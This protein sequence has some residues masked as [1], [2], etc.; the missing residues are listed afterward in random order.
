MASDGDGDGDGDIRD[1]IDRAFG[2]RHA[3]LS[4][5]ANEVRCIVSNPAAPYELAEWFVRKIPRLPHDDPAEGDSAPSKRHRRAGGANA[6]DM[7]MM[8]SDH[9]GNSDCGEIGVRTDLESLLEKEL[10][11]LKQHVRRPPS[12]QSPSAFNQHASKESAVDVLKQLYHAIPVLPS[13]TKPQPESVLF[14]KCAQSTMAHLSVLRGLMPFENSWFAVFEYEKYS[15]QDVLKYNRHVLCDD[16]DATEGAQLALSDMKKRFLIYQLMRVLQFFHERGLVMAGFC[17]SNILLTD[18]LWIRLGALPVMRLHHSDKTSLGEPGK[19]ELADTPHRNPPRRFVRMYRDV[20]DVSDRSITE[21]WC[22]GEV[23][24]FEYLML[25]NTASGR[26]MVDG[27]FHPVLPWVTDFSQRH[28]GWRDLTKSK[29]RINKGDSQLDRTYESSMIPHHITESVDSL[30]EITY[31]IYMARRT[32]MALLRQVVRS[33][34]QA[35]E[36]PS[37]M[38]RMY[39]WTPD[40][41]IPEFYMDASIFKSMHGDEMDDLAWPEWCESAE[42]FIHIHRAMLESDEVSQHLHH[43]IN[44]NFG[45]CLSGDEAVQAKNVPLRV[46]GG[47]RL[48]KSPGFAQLFTSAHPARRVQEIAASPPRRSIILDSQ[49]QADSNDY[50]QAQRLASYRPSDLKKKKAQMLSKALQIASEASESTPST[51]NET[52]VAAPKITMGTVAAT[53]H[54][55]AGPADPRALSVA[56]LRHRKKGNKARPRS[57]NSAEPNSPTGVI[58]P[59]GGHV[60]SPS[61]SRLATAIPKFFNSDSNGPHSTSS[62]QSVTSHFHAAPAGF[63]FSGDATAPNSSSMSAVS[64]DQ[65]RTQSMPASMS[66]VSTSSSGSLSTFHGHNNVNSSSSGIHIGSSFGGTTSTPSSGSSHIFKEIWQQISKPDEEESSLLSDSATMPEFDWSDTDYSCL[67]DVGIQLLN[68]GLPINL[69]TPNEFQSKHG[70]A[71]GV[72]ALEIERQ[73]RFCRMADSVISAAYSIPSDVLMEH[74]EID[75]LHMSA[76]DLD[77][78]ADLF[79]LGCVIAEIYTLTPLFSKNTVVEYVNAFAEVSQRRRQSLLELNW[80]PLAGIQPTSQPDVKLQVDYDADIQCQLR[81]VPL[82]IK[83]TITALIYPNPRRRL[84]LSGVLYGEEVS[85]LLHQFDRQRQVNAVV[86]GANTHSSNQLIVASQ[87]AAATGFSPAQ[88]SMFPPEFSK[89]YEFLAEFH[90]SNQWLERFDVVRKLLPQISTLPLPA[91]QTI[92]PV[93]THFFQA[94]SHTESIC[95]ERVVTAIVFLLPVLAQQL[96]RNGTA[97]ELL[98]DVLRVYENGQLSFLLKIC[99]AS[100]E[101]LKNLVRAFG[102]AIFIDQFLPVI[103]DWLATPPYAP[104]HNDCG[105]IPPDSRKAPLFATEASSIIAVAFGELVSVDILGPSLSVKYVLPMILPLLGKIKAKWNK[106]SQSS[107]IVQKNAA[108]STAMI[109]GADD[110]GSVTIQSAE[111]IHITYLCKEALYDTHFIADAVLLVCREMGEVPICATLLPYI[112]DVLPKLITLAERAGSARIEGVPAELGREIYVILCILR[113]QVRSMSETAVQRELLN[114]RPDSLIDLL[115]LISPP[116]LH[117]RTAAAVMAAASHSD[118]SDGFK[119]RKK[120][121]MQTLSYMRHENASE[122]RA[123]TAIGLARTIVAV[124]QKVG[125]EVAAAVTPLIQGINKFLTRCSVVYSELEVSNFQWHMA[126]E[127]VSEFC[128]PLK[129]L[130]GR[131]FFDKLFP[132]VHSS[133]VLQLLLLPIQSTATNVTK[134]LEGG[135]DSIIKTPLP[136]TTH[137]DDSVL[138][139]TREVTVERHDRARTLTDAQAQLSQVIAYPKPLLRFAYRTLRLNTVKS[140]GFLH[141]PMGL[142]SKDQQEINEETFA[143]Q[144]ERR[145]RKHQATSSSNAAAASPAKS[146]I[147]NASDQVWLRPLVTRPFM[148]RSAQEAA[149]AHTTTEAELMGHGS[150]AGDIGQSWMFL[151]EVRSTIKAHS[152]CV[153]SLS[154]DFDEEVALSGSKNGSCRAWRLANH[155]THVQAAVYTDSPITMVQHAMDGVNALA[156]EAGCVYIWDLSTSHARAKLPFHDDTVQGMAVLRTMPFGG[157]C[158]RAHDAASSG[159]G[160]ATRFCQ[161]GYADVVVATTRKVHTIDLRCGPRVVT[162]WRADARDAT[163][164]SA[165]AAVVSSSSGV[166]YQ[167]VGM[168]SGVVTLLCQ[169][170][171]TLVLQWQAL[172]SKVVKIVQYA[173]DLVLVVGAEKE[174]R[175]WALVPN[176]KPRLCMVLQ[177]LPEGLTAH[178]V[179]VQSYT[180]MALMYVVAG[181][182]VSTVRLVTEPTH[183]QSSGKSSGDI[184]ALRLEPWSITE[185]SVSS[186]LKLGKSK[187]AAQSIAVLPLRQVVVLGGDDGLI[188]LCV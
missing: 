50:R 14:A 124:C 58:G 166:V 142:D 53:S 168:S 33:N 187:V 119:T 116:F 100:P 121:V 175:V 120:R 82:N 170:M 154:V 164:M 24:N 34:F 96:G 71:S 174:A 90:M 63:T 181:S 26:R 165:V 1:E 102:N 186:S 112:F 36:Y 105:M 56:K 8:L 157:V 72:E 66:M 122:L 125:P 143:T 156:A 12:P 11:C 141:V 180:D 78:A 83:N 37:K 87:L 135:L 68:V 111:G 110:N 10:G 92:L 134:D 179:T 85:S 108:G 137:K 61:V 118:T 169:R 2:W 5:D 99:L 69:P 18:N 178:Q 17:P 45:V 75:L 140:T 155:P 153:R 47:G 27:V 133:S 25:L 145:R 64:T 21:R 150:P 31:Y 42:E 80:I 3:Y 127:I 184:I 19:D 139:N 152:S 107:V 185:A 113:H 160:A 67:D 60:R 84:E 148:T 183:S 29:F 74:F 136:P 177:G 188:K 35:R 163:P 149:G 162:D 171:G 13:D 176:R 103:V 104:E 20:A 88:C 98:C 54:S 81:N 44:L 101:V 73:I 97:S 7:S 32:P 70:A 132:I 117:P 30:S 43:W 51:F 94:S 151:G 131:E 49:I 77:R 172:D 146:A 4:N 39:E 62:S 52:M 79:A 93:L 91:F 22:D 23:S 16:D 46:R 89:L 114:R 57:H 173:P 129:Q 144:E 161:V 9:G 15:L 59:G 41:C 126:S 6:E 147:R 38:N 48:C 158:A 86:L 95:V 28:G 182:K 159:A 138:R 123:F 106:A 76:Y 167:A 128:T 130:F 115:A 109:G 65:S 40:E 55:F